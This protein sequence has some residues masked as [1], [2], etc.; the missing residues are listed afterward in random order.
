MNTKELIK[1]ALEED[2]G[3]TDLTTDSLDLAEIQKE[4]KIIA[5]EF[6]I[7]CGTKIAKEVFLQV[8]SSL[9]IE[10]LKKDGSK[11]KKGDIIMK[12]TGNSSS[13]LKAERVALNLMQRLSGI[14]TTT[15]KFAEQLKFAK[16]YDT[17]K[18]T[19]LFREIEKYAVK[20]GGGE[21]HRFGLYDEILIK[22]NHIESIGSIKEV[23]S[24]IRKN[25]PN[26]KIEIEVKNYYE[27]IEALE[28]KADII[29]LDN[30]NK[31][32]IKD[33]I[34]AIKEFKPVIEVSGGVTVDTVYK[35]D[36]KG[37]GRISV[38]ALT[39]SVKS[40]DLSLIIHS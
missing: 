30:M 25:C 40:L 18:T 19:P 31:K 35:Y 13:I 27:F 20:I 9:K 38:G 17:R 36:I 15:N 32:Q 34:L 12:I 8:D 37:V 16:V 28:E 22:E 23:I 24:K 33:C 3:K 10:I 4:A 2:L 5:K 1:L 11:V 6:G 7:I 14:S 21:N 39:H 29:L 26:K